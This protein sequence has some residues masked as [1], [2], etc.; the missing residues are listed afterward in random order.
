MF[1]SEEASGAAE[2]RLHFVENK[3]SAMTRGKFPRPREIGGR[4]QVDAGFALDR[5]EEE[6]GNLRSVASKTR[7]Q[8][9]GIAEFDTLEAGR[10]RPESLR[11]MRLS[12]QCKCAEGFAVKGA[13]RGEDGRPASARA[14]PR[15]R[16][17]HGLGARRRAEAAREITGRETGETVWRL[18]EDG[19]A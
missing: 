5:L 6:P 16:G 14:G 19:C 3:G 10:K 12:R 11:V 4:R 13:G 9:A 15:D 8:C 18:R 2:A 17:F 1:A 7:F